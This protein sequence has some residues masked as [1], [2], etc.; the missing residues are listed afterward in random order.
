MDQDE[1]WHR[2]RPRHRP[3][4]VLD[5]DPAPPK[6]GH[7]PNLGAPKFSVHVHCGQTAGW[8][9][10][11]LGIAYWKGCRGCAAADENTASLPLKTHFSGNR[12]S[13]AGSD[14]LKNTALWLR[15]CTMYWT[16]LTL[17]VIYRRLKVVIFP[18]SKY[19]V[20][21]FRSFF[22]NSNFVIVSA[23]IFDAK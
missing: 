2:G 3:H 4:I 9:K 18:E 23:K 15:H 11:A 7:S 13:A 22:V 14:F 17:Y 20:R 8:I 1:T 12:C 10:T 21:F 5:G 6:M 19:N 16:I